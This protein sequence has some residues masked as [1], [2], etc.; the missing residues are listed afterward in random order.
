MTIFLLFLRSWWRF[1]WGTH[2]RLWSFLHL[3]HWL[4]LWTSDRS[5]SWYW[6]GYKWRSSELL[7]KG[8]RVAVLMFC[9]PK[10]SLGEVL[11]SQAS[12]S[13][14]AGGRG[15]GTSY[16]S[17]DRLH[18]TLQTWAWDTHPSSPD[19][20]PRIPS[21][22]WTW[23]LGYWSPCYWHLMVITGDLFKLVHLRTYS[24]QYWHLV[25]ATETY[26]V[27]KAGSTH[28]TGMLSCFNNLTTSGKLTLCMYFQNSNL[29][30]T[31]NDLNSA[32]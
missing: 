30:D 3:Q 6:L 12:V 16:A 8:I 25:A 10:W 18:C 11:F 1:C 29:C 9:V 22:P 21:S 5:A 26:M 20:G 7:D 14:S 27:G 32:Y 4:C 23:N 19:M 24:P 2:V 28:P 31:N 15:V 17:W 13:H